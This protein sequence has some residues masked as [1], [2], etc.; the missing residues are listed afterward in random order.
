MEIGIRVAIGWVIVGVSEPV[1]C[2]WFGVMMVG[3]GRISP[4]VILVAFGVA[5]DSETNI[6]TLQMEISLQPYKE[7]SQTE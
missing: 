2:S 5:V 3:G 7:F 4:A 1:G 6:Y